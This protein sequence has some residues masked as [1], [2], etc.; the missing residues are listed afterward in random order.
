L[1]VAGIVLNNILPPDPSDPSIASNRCELEL[2]CIPPVLA[3]LSYRAGQFDREVAWA[4]LA[5]APLGQ[6][7]QAGGAR[8]GCTLASR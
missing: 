7:G 3:E 2:R 8:P 6:P 4:E 5:A 1:Q